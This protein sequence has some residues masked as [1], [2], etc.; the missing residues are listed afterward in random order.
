MAIF[1]ASSLAAG[2]AGSGSA[3]IASRAVQGIG[4]AMLTP[5]TL[6]I[7]MAA[8]TDLKERAT[9]IGIWTASAALGLAVGPVAGGLISQN[10]D[11][12]GS[13]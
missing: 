13:S 4:A 9:A 2:L 10:L 12:A 11:W 3:L 8:F 7:I 5:A 1:T 6:A